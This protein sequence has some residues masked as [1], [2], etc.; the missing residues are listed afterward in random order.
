MDD[1]VVNVVVCAPITKGYHY[2]AP[3]PLLPG[4]RVIVPFRNRKLIGVVFPKHEEEASKRYRLKEV[5]EVVDEKPYLSDTL[6]DISQW[7]SSYYLH[8]LGEVVRTM[9]PLVKFQTGGRKY[10]RTTN[11]VELCA[12]KVDLVEVLEKVFPTRRSLP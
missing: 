6:I 2:V 9:L 10:A 4:T 5:I 7:L 8:P 12:G 3:R 1:R 11:A